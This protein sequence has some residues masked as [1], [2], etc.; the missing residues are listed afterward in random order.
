[1]K[2]ALTLSPI[3]DTQDAVM[4]NFNREDHDD[5]GNRLHK[6]SGEAYVADPPRPS[7]FL[8]SDFNM[9]MDNQC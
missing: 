3:V 2:L 7:T 6:R 8:E 9:V 1:M 5:S 4:N